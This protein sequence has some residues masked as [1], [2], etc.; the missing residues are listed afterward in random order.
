M[1]A[2][3]CNAKVSK[4]VKAARMFSYGQSRR[5]YVVKKEI[6]R[7]LAKLKQPQPGKK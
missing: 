7:G 6:L 5:P 2:R 4:A 3:L 1:V